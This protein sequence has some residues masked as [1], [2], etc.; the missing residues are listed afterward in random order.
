[1]E[2]DRPR[3]TTLIASVVAVAAACAAS[4][5]VAL[6]TGGGT[7]PAAQRLEYR[8][9]PGTCKL[10][11][12]GTLAAYLPDPIIDPGP[13]SARGPSRTSTCHW[14]S[15][16]DHQ[17]R[18]LSVAISL[19]DG[20]DG[21]TLA[22]EAFQTAPA[23]T[24]GGGGGE[25]V[26]TTRHSGGNGL[27]QTTRPVGGVGDQA[28]AVY[29]N[30]N[31]EHDPQLQSIT[32]AVR[33]GNVVA[34]V[35]YTVDPVTASL[36]APPNR[37]GLADQ[38]TL[39]R[40]LLTVLARPATAAAIR[41]TG[42]GGPRYGDPLHACRLVTTAT[43]HAYLPGATADASNPDTPQAN[44]SACLWDT[45]SGS[46]S[47]ALILGIFGPADQEQ[48]D[49]RVMYETDV[50]E[51][52]QSED[53]T[54]VL[55]TEPVAGLGGQATAIY[56]ADSVIR[57]EGVTLLV[58]SGD[59]VIQLSYQVNGDPQLGPPPPPRTAQ[60]ATV[61]ALARAILAALPVAG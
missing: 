43:L 53:Q 44:L 2:R 21:L 48:L 55:R 4:L 46:P 20:P 23:A 5:A 54:T 22:R 29:V 41:I 31:P 37:A 42:P 35:S 34:A 11:T 17:E 60:L 18:E 7:R 3:R 49:P 19:Y 25:I 59:A 38:V 47:L 12:A 33:S 8:S 56:T 30:V 10:L 32:L 39:A 61:T 26:L 6:S 9:L 57:S 27:A 14:T 50:Q 13:S 40:D 45:Q 15:I 24:G 36:S 52:D 51:Q 16:T 28:K 58:W 1:M